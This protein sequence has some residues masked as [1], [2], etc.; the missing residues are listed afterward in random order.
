MTYPDFER[1]DLTFLGETRPVFRAG[2][3]PAVIVMHEIPGLHP[4]VAEFGRK[5]IAR[6]FTVFMPSLVGTPG[7]PVTPQY[8]LETM[9]KVCVMREFTV[10]ATRRNSAITDWLRALARHAHAECGGPGVGAVGMCL[11]GGFALAMAAE[12]CI[13]A[14][15]LSQPS[16]PFPVTKQQRNDLGVDNY[17]L[18]R[19]KR[20]AIDDDLCVLGLRFTSDR[21]VPRARFERLRSELGDNFIAVEIDSSRGNPHGIPRTAHSVLAVHYV[22][23]PNHPTQLALEQVMTFLSDR[24][25]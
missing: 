14:P 6:G 15:V 9:A 21:L 23:E 8:S 17:T 20:R 1:L 11:T 12:D 19:V 5:V 10:W 13:L 3:G 4:Q 25:C 22:D 24:L 18:A 16:L 7:K 2:T